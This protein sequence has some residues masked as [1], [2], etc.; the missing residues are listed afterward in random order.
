MSKRPTMAD[1]TRL[2][3]KVAGEPVKPVSKPVKAS[4]YR[5]QRPEWNGVRF[6]SKKELQRYKELLTMEHTGHVSNLR[7]QVEYVLI[8]A[9]GKVRKCS[10]FAD[11]VYTDWHGNEVVEDVKP[12]VKKT[13]KF[14]L[15]PEFIIKQKLM[16]QVYGITIKLF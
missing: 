15:L 16:L 10:Y 4:K 13:G 2:G 3:I 14:R 5:N 6:D 11:F 1:L 9:N 7:R 8:P 12:Y